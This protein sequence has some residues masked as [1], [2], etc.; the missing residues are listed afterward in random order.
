MSLEPDY[1]RRY[2]C[3][4]I[5]LYN[6]PGHENSLQQHPL[7][8]EALKREEELLL[9]VDPEINQWVC[10]GMLAVTIGLMAATAEWVGTVAV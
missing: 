8:P 9:I 10:L 5:Y 6:P 4:R 7:A 2:L 1:F 3:S